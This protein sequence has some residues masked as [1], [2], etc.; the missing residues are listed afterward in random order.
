MASHSSATSREET[1]HVISSTK[2]LTSST[3]RSRKQEQEAGQN[4]T[5]NLKGRSKNA[6]G[7]NGT[8]KPISNALRRRAQAVIKDK[9]IDPQ[10]RAVIRYGL[11]TNDP[12][13]AELVRRADAG[14]TIIDRAGRL[15]VDP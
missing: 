15:I 3:G 7:T 11:E 9:S 12:L 4:K 6:R 5:L 8:F 1:P 14:E 10:S 13:L 2:S